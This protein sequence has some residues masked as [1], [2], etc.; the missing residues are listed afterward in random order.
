[1]VITDGTI[2]IWLW[3][4][5]PGWAP[6]FLRRAA[7]EKKAILGTELLA[8]KSR[9]PSRHV[10][11]KCSLCWEERQRKEHL[12]QIIAGTL[13]PSSGQV[14]VSGRVTALL[15]LGSGF[16]PGVTGGKTSI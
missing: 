12:M 15:E 9:F 6:K 2:Q 3:N 10:Q 8:L 11:E 5:V 7:E 16:N 13:Q 4:Q 14:S 1:V